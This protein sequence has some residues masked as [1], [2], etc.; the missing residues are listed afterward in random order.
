MGSEHA[1]M[2]AGWTVFAILAVAITFV[3]AYWTFGHR[4]AAKVKKQQQDLE[5]QKSRIRMIPQVQLQSSGPP[6]SLPDPFT[7]NGVTTKVCSKSRPV[8][9]LRKPGG[10]LSEPEIVPEAEVWEAVG[11]EQ[12]PEAIEPEAE[13]GALEA[14]V[15]EYP[16]EAKSPGLRGSLDLESLCGS[17]FSSGFPDSWGKTT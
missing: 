3:G 4:K 10:H 13:P 11:Q 16:L 5:L 6:M 7:S 15:K 12:P 2:I 9:L 8:S 14:M 17:S 1:S